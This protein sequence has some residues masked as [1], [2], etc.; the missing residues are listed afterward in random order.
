LLFNGNGLLFISN[1]RGT[2]FDNAQCANAEQLDAWRKYWLHVY[3]VPKPG[4]FGC[5]LSYFFLCDERLM[6][7]KRS[8]VSGGWEARQKITIGVP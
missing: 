4:W 7:I 1:L 5:A 8:P 3:V 6:N 2:Y